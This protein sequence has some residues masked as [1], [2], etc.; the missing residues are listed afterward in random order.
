MAQDKQKAAVESHL[1]WLRQKNVLPVE[2]KKNVPLMERDSREPYVEFL[3]FFVMHS[4]FTIPDL[5]N[6]KPDHGIVD[7]YRTASILGRVTHIVYPRTYT[8]CSIVNL[9]LYISTKRIL[10]WPTKKDAPEKLEAALASYKEMSILFR[11]M[12][13]DA[14]KDSFA[15]KD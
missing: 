14:I 6:E 8:R 12:L 3:Y 15:I 4:L 10:E 2:Y 13:V 1:E 7:L 5:L 9:A 11:A